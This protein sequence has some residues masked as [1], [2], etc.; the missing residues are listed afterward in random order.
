M[1]HHHIG[2][3]SNFHIVSE[4]FLDLTRSYP[5]SPPS[6]S[7]LLETHSVPLLIDPAKTALV[8]IDMQNFFLSSALGRMRGKGHEAQA[9]LHERAVP[10][11]RKAGIQV[12]WLNWGLTEED[13]LTMPPAIKRA[14]GGPGKSVGVRGGLAEAGE[15]LA[16]KPGIVKDK[17]I[18]CGLGADMGSV[19]VDGEQINAGKLLMRDQW[20]AALHAPLDQLYHEGTLLQQNPDV[21]LHKDRMSGMWGASTMCQDFL[22]KKGITTLLFA[23]VN[24]DQCVAGTLTDSY[25]KGYDCILLSDGA[26]TTSP[27]FAQECVEYNAIKSW[28]FLSDCQSLEDSVKRSEK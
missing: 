13:I 28:G 19:T 26:A 25:A 24:T 3:D 27:S 9:Q 8:I 7:L 16:S 5:S 12:V 23:G 4:D 1:E 6:T 21:L 15:K 20:N 22:D 2:N 10:A 17:R 14:F 11:A 18:Y